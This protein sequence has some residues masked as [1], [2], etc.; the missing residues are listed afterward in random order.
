LGNFEE[1]R[2]QL[3]GDLITPESPEY[4]AAR[5]LWNGMIDKRPGAIARCLGVG[6]VQSCVRFAAESDTPLAI[7]GG[8]HNVA[9]LGSCDGGLVIDLSRMKGA[10]VNPAAR[11]VDAQAGMCWGDFDRE[12]QVFGLATTGGLI[13]TT[14]ISGLTL[15]GGF[16][17][18][19]GRC[20]LVCDNVLS[21]E[22][23]TADGEVR[24]ASAEEHPDLYWALRGGGG[25]FG[26]VTSIQ[27]RLYPIQR[28]LAGHLIHPIERGGE[29]L[30][31]YRD[32]A[33]AAPDELTIYASSLVLPDG[34][35]VLAITPCY[36][37]DNLE[38]GA[39]LM[40]PLRKFGPPVADTVA[41]MPYTA[42]Q[43][44]LDAAAPYGIRSY[45]KSN[46]LQTLDDNAIDTYVSFARS[47]TSP[48]A[49]FILEHCHGAV[50]RV[51]A[52]AT[53]VS[54]RDHTFNLVILTMWQD[55]DD[56]RHIDFTRRFYDAM[57]PY[58]AGSVYVNA[59]SADDGG[60][61]REAYGP[62][63]SRLAEIKAKYDPTNLFRLNNNIR[64]AAAAAG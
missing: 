24:R 46:F 62:N 61:V 40:E 38:E 5:R 30:R 59:L 1:L 2:N 54:L 3:R 58:S 16:G 17:W 10:H 22:V 4:D 41:P 19:M 11:T 48:H 50:Q 13:S 28:V 63:Y 20:G 47:R 42:L 21:F 8:G 36:C 55:A 6:D 43:Q 33:A 39:R 37:G 60:R 64:P 52:D 18:L 32:F 53:A 56:A 7:R 44:M 26:A 12:T 25:N 34:F 29:V 27:Y 15:G 31:F 9:G 57:Q 45:W 14:G 23:V 49:G 51:A 35:Q